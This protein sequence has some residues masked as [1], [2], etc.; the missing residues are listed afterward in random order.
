MRKAVL[1]LLEGFTVA[2]FA[3]GVYGL[4]GLFLATREWIEPATSPSRQSRP[5]PLPPRPALVPARAPYLAPT[6]L[7]HPSP[8]HPG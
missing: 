4:P 2:A 6:R 5:L 8:M 3:A 7:R 1:W